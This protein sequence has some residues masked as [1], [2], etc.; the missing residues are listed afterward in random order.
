MK[1]LA[2]QAFF[3]ALRARAHILRVCQRN[4]NTKHV[5]AL[6]VDLKTRRYAPE[7][8]V[9]G[10]TPNTPKKDCQRGEFNHGVAAPR[11]TVSFASLTAV[12]SGQLALRAGLSAVKPHLLQ[13]RYLPCHRHGSCCAHPC[14]HPCALRHSRTLL[15]SESFR[16]RRERY[17][18]DRHAY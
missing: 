16:E 12:D 6:H 3:P 13:R 15:M 8:N 2:T 10:N 18:N 17:R 14:A 7:H 4:A 5:K 11:F 1:N 9:L